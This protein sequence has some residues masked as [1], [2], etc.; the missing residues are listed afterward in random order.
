[1]PTVLLCHFDGTNGQTTTVDNSASAHV[2]TLSSGI[3]LNTAQ[4][5]FGT[6]SLDMAGAAG[7]GVVSTPATA[8]FQFGSGQFTVECWIRI[9]SALGGVNYGFVSQWTAANNCG[10]YLG[11]GNSGQLCF[12]WSLTGSD[13]PLISAAWAPALNTWHHIAADRDAS[14][15]LRLYLNGVVMASSTVASTFFASAA[16]LQLANN[17]FAATKLLGFLDEARIVKGAAAYGGAFTPPTSPLNGVAAPTTQ[18]RAMVL[19]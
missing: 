16:N 7:S 17:T 1:M 4:Q 10:F 15:V 13:T 11:Q 12:I 18:A 9:T 19:A 5:R 3:V 8:D 2:L 6:S 14:N